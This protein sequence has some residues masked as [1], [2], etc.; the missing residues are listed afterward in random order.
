MMT[1]NDAKQQEAVFV[2]LEDLVPQNHILRKVDKAIDLS[3]VYDYVKDLYSNIGRPSIDPVVLIK[4]AIVDKLFGYHSMRRTLR[5]AEV[6]L[7]IRWYLG[8]GI[9]EKLPH[10]SDFSKTY[11]RKFSKLVD[12]KNKKGEVVRQDTIFAVIFDEVLKIAMNKN[13]LY[14]EHIYMDSTHIKAHANKKKV[15][16]HIVQEERKNYQDELDSE[17]NAL[18]LKEGLMLE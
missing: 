11:S 17:I 9:E 10:F 5:E 13:F 7:A 3:F 12:I 6:N 4:L 16:K 1:K 2:I 14:P 8:Y 18:C 15:S